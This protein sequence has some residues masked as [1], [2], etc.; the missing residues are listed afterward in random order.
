MI[1]YFWTEKLLP[2][3]PYTTLGYSRELHE[4]MIVRQIRQFLFLALIN[5]DALISSSSLP[6]GDDVYERTY[7]KR[8]FIDKKLSAKYDKKNNKCSLV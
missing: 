1:V 5:D 4:T 7:C 6:Q 3:N 2:Q 8:M